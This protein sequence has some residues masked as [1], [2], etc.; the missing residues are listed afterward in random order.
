MKP[1]RMSGYRAGQNTVTISVDTSSLNALLDQ[2]GADAEAAARPAA[3]AAAQVLYEEVQNNVRRMGRK[4]GNLFNAIYQ[5]YSAA[6]SGP[7]KAT[8]HIGWRTTRGGGARAP[9]GHWLEFGHIQRYAAY[10]G[11]DGKWHT[12]VRPSMRGKPKPKGNASQSV[13]DAYYVMRK[14]GP[15][16]IAAHPFIRPA[17][18]KFPQALAAAEAKLLEFILNGKT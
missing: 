10:I 6:N 15:Q 11:K 1:S 3:Q 4:T 12:A 7:G 9:H 8:Y 17:A 13:K 18:S 16:Q 5:A 14:G 2:L